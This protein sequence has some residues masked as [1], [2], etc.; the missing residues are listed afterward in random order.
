MS[1]ITCSP[2]PNNEQNLRN[3]ART[4]IVCSSKT[5][6]KQNQRNKNAQ[7]LQ[8]DTEQEAILAFISTGANTFQEPTLDENEELWYKQQASWEEIHL[9][10]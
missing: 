8:D 5:N 9:I 4:P 2:K 6:P 7:H 3:K 10:L 1:S